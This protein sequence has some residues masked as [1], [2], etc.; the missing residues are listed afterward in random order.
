LGK[1]NFTGPNK[2]QVNGKELQFK[3]ACIATGGR[4]FVPDYPGSKEIRYFTSDNI[5]NLTVQPK[6]MLIVGSGPIGSE[7]G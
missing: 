3:K 2:V 4:P 7:L 5:F 1:A 6:Q